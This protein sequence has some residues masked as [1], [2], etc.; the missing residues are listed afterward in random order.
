MDLI[1]SRRALSTA[2]HFTIALI[3]TY[4]E[5]SRTLSDLLQG[6]N[7]DLVDI[8]ASFE[9]AV[10][11]AREVES[12][13]DVI[14]T[15]GG[16]GQYIKQVASIPV[17]SIPISP[18]DLMISVSQLSPEVERIAFINYQRAIFGTQQ[19]EQLFHKQIFSL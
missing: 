8:Y 3:A 7:I 9:R 16:T 5:M 4:P 12:R 2:E 10:T 1:T 14:L 18:F 11:A 13:V 19:I 6:T 17:I 15:R